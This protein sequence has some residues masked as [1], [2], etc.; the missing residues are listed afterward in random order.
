[1]SMFKK[2]NIETEYESRFFSQ[3]SFYNVEKL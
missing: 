2:A 1:M 3:G